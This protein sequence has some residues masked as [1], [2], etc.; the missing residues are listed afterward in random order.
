MI[1]YKNMFFSLL[2]LT[3][4][5]GGLS[6]CEK[7]VEPETRD[8]SAFKG[9]YPSKDEPMQSTYYKPYAGYVGDV[10]PFYDPVNKDFKVF[11]LQD[12]RPNPEGTYHPIWAVTTKN[13]AS[14]ESLGECVPCGSLDEQDAALGTGSAIYCAESKRYYLY[15]TGERYAPRMKEGDNM[16][17]VLR[18][19]S[20]DGKTWTKDPSFI[21]RGN[22]YGYDSRDFRDPLLRHDTDGYHMYIATRKGGKGTIAEF[23]SDDC[24]AWTCAGDFMNMMWDR[25]YECPDIFQM[26]EWWY[27]VYSEQSGFMRR[28]QYFKGKTLDDLKACTAGDAGIWPD[29][30]EGFL[31]SRGMYAG[32]TASDGTNRYLWGWVPTRKGN[33][34]LNVGDDKEEPEWGGNL[35]CHRIYQ[36]ADGSLTLAPIDAV[37]A[38]Y[39]QTQNASDRLLYHNHLQMTVTT[40]NADDDFG[41]SLV[42]SEDTAFTMRVHAESATRRKIN[43]ETEGKY[44]G[45]T[46]IGWIDGYMF[47]T[48]A[49]NVYHVDVFTD[50]SV[51]TF[52]LSDSNGKPI[53]NYTNRIYGIARNQWRVNTYD[54]NVKVENI[55]VTTY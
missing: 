15:Y 50:N 7:S 40:E 12:F 29:D 23:V 45:C 3:L 35:V 39:T 41:I 17:A 32:K 46:F 9:I 4:L 30:H 2:T 21:L 10:M 44:T 27:L 14:Y 8:W 5:I 25:F 43:F 34:T 13:G 52:Y 22:D 1:M 26:G 38:K 55:K 48:P 16:Q 49:D 19:Y 36:H 18:A 6:S 28:V 31:D 11:Y 20:A 24:K 51:V 47:D 54:K 33:N 42:C 53:A 37:A